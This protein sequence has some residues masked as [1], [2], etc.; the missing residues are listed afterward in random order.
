MDKP[1]L[2]TRNLVILAF[3]VFFTRLGQ[4]LE[5][6]VATNFYVQ[7]LGIGG[8]QI[9]WLAGIREIPGLLLMFLAA[10]LM[11]LP[12]PYRS[13]LAIFAMAI[14]YGLFA[15]VH[16]YMALIACAVLASIGFHLWMPLNSSLG[17]GLVE[18]SYSGR[19][20]GRLNGIGALASLGGM[21]L[22]TLTVDRLGIR[23]FFI[24]SGLALLIGTVAVVQLPKGIGRDQENRGKGQRLVFK[25]RYWLYYVLIFFEGSRTQVFHT[26][27]AWVLAQ[28]YGM[29]ASRL[30]LV[31][32]ASGLLNCL[33]SSK[34]GAWIDHFGERAV[35]TASYASMALC[36]V[37]YAVLHNVWL[38]SA[39]YV[40]INF[41]VLS[42]VALDT[43]VNRISVPGDLVP[44]LSAGVSVNHITSVAMSL[45]AGSLLRIVGYEVLSWGAAL[46]ILLS[47]PFALMVRRPALEAQAEQVPAA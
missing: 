17:M 33:L 36:F 40:L 8:D 18:K 46:V 37:G 44:T 16:S 23:T 27:G 41:L 2:W 10:L 34:L 31:L 21:L 19:I 5:A 6:G 11:P 22:I 3:T 30:P 39:L 20:L 45:V 14:G 29:D 38:L 15:W 26:F 12:L 28:F 1:P 25:R 4:G 32:I 42:R 43:Y 13:A 9:L 24:L 35:L 47:L 7:E